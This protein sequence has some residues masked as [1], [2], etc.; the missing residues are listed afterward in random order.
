MSAVARLLLEAGAVVS[1]SDAV[2]S[3]VLDELRA[4]GVRVDVGHDASHGADAD[5]VMWSPAVALDN[6]ELAAARDRGALMV[7]RADLFEEL[8]QRYRVIGLA[9]THGKTTATSM[10]VHVLAAA[11][12][13]AGRLVG[14]P[15]RGVGAA[16][17]D[18][19]DGLVLEVDESFG[20]FAR[21]TPHALGLLNV[22]AD[23]LDHYGSLAELE[24]QFTAL[25]ERTTGPVVAWVDDEGA[26]RVIAAAGRPCDAVA[27]DVPARW[28][29]EDVRVSREGSAFSVRGPHTNVDVTLTVP[30]RHA[31]ADAAVVA[32]LAIVDGVDLEAVAAG[33]GAF[34]GV[35]RRF[36]H[37]GQWGG[38]AVY[39]DYAH[40][41]GE[42]A[43]TLEALRAIGFARVTAVFQPHR[44]TRT[45]ALA[46]AFAPSFDAADHVVVTDVYSA[47]EPNPDGV[48]GEAVAAPLR[49]R[50]RD[51]VR[52]APSPSDVVAAMV[53][54]RDASDVIV[55]L[56]AGDIA[57]VIN[58]LPGG[59]A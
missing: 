50:R 13:D 3:P 27:R 58:D 57:T 30:G 12:R 33:L 18:G 9:G 47:G 39:E 17:H 35:P 36:E 45:R 41:P 59:V 48:T 22:E 2:A 23:H 24:T 8:G 40:L 44:V 49:A 32:V 46:D 42:I 37:R 54:L 21:L 11:G 14:A 20:T 52:Y 56:G 55:V 26:R 4:V 10:M 38:V 28:R 1:G 53:E 29:V 34:Q 16:G 7:S 5:V 6:V 15:V 51:A 43:A 19:P 31:V 25:V